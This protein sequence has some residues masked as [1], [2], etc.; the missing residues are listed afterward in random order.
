ME[1]G[2]FYGVFGPS[3]FKKSLLSYEKDMKIYDFSEN[4][5]SMWISTKVIRSKYKWEEMRILSDK[6]CP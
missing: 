4:I 1:K 6:C 2:W 3:A 5:I